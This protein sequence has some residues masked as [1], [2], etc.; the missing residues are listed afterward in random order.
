MV[1]HSFYGPKIHEGFVISSGIET[2]GDVFRPL[3]VVEKEA[4]HWDPFRIECQIVGLD[5]EVAGV[6]FWHMTS[7]GIPDADDVSVASGRRLLAYIVEDR[8]NGHPTARYILNR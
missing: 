7:L 5:V 4:S 6:K 3:F 1:D 2:D 8:V